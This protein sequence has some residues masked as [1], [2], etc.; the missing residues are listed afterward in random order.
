MTDKDPDP[1]LLMGDVP[2]R[3]I[4]SLPGQLPSPVVQELTAL[5]AGPAGAEDRLRDIYRPLEGAADKDPWP[6]G[7]HRI[8]R[9]ELA[10]I[11]VIEFN[12]EFL[13]QIQNIHGRIQSNG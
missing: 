13:G 12:T 1:W 8:D 4:D 2:F 10:K 11:V 3:W 9:I 7:H 6:V 5:G